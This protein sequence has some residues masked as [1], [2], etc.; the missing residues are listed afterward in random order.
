MNSLLQSKK[1][2]KKN[3]RTA[4]SGLKNEAS[5]LKNATQECGVCFESTPDVKMVAGD[6]ENCGCSHMSSFC[7]TCVSRVVD[8][9]ISEGAFARLVCLQPGCHRP[10]STAV[11]SDFATPANLSLFEEH[12]KAKARAAVWYLRLLKSAEG[13]ANNMHASCQCLWRRTVLDSRRC[14][15]CAFVIEKDGGCNHMTCRRCNFEFHWCCGHP[16]RGSYQHTSTVC[17]ARRFFPL[18]C[19]GLWLAAC[20]MS[21]PSVV[22]AVTFL[23]RKCYEFALPLLLPL[24]LPLWTYINDLYT[25]V[26]FSD[27]C[28]TLLAVIATVYSANSPH[29]RRDVFDLLHYIPRV[30]AYLLAQLAVSTA[31]WWSLSK[32]VEYS[33]WLYFDHTQHW[34]AAQQLSLY[35]VLGALLAR[36]CYRTCWQQPSWSASALLGRRRLIVL[37]GLS[38]YLFFLS[39][40]CTAAYSLW[41][42]VPVVLTSVLVPLFCLV[43]ETLP[44]FCRN[45]DRNEFAVFAVSTSTAL[46]CV[47]CSNLKLS[48]TVASIYIVVVMFPFYV[49]PHYNMVDFQELVYFVDSTNR[50]DNG[51]K[52]LI[53]ILWMFFI[54]LCGLMLENVF[55]PFTLNCIFPVIALLLNNVLVALTSICNLCMYVCAVPCISIPLLGVVSLVAVWYY[56]ARVI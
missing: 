28:N 22:S 26:T 47:W 17:T 31:T 20:L 37:A 11:I 18:I 27:K 3:T 55:I 9:H 15:S 38:A 19:L 53:C 48:S 41:W 12:L 51:D 33:Q 16:Y 30:W 56:F 34:G 52:W 46:T 2:K 6:K 32:G 4:V 1:K 50:H 23:P 49:Y 25:L 24:L 35:L 13:A 36:T 40:A 8:M 21:S 45:F 42:K 5:L 7:E 44:A 39:R 10:L 14:P 29:S 54:P 43:K